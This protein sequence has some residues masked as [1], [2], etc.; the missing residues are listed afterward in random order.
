[1]AVEES[2][3]KEIPQSKIEILEGHTKSVIVFLSLYLRCISA[4]GVR[5]VISLPPR[6]F[7]LFFS[8]ITDQPIPPLAFGSFRIPLPPIRFSPC[9]KDPSAPTQPFPAA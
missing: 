4:S 2:D 8:H 9:R 1:M 5:T 3:S 7:F 6:C